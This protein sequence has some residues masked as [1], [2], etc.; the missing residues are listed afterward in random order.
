[1]GSFPGAPASAVD[2]SFRDVLDNL[3][4]AGMLMASARRGPWVFYLDTTYASLSSTASLSGAYR[5]VR[6][7]SETTTF[8]LALGRT[9]RETEQGALQAY[10]GARAWWLNN[11]IML[12]ETGGAVRN[13]EEDANWIDP[14]VG[15]AGNHRISDRWTL[16]GAAEV[17]G[18]GV[19][20]DS[21]WSVVFGGTFRVNETLDLNVGWRHLDVDYEED[22]VLY[23]AGQSGPLV[24]ATFRF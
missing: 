1:V 13:Q 7:D 6:V 21:E 19:G 23:D 12:R 20:A 2:L 17:G 24:G 9:I 4:L 11:E 15:I 8:S 3:D 16:F 10:V 22:G 5:D 18:F 14:L